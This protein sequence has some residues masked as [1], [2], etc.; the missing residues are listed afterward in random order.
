MIHSTTTHPGRHRPTLAAALA[1][2][3]ALLLGACS[4][5][6]APSSSVPPSLSP[7]NSAG[8]SASSTPS[9]AGAP[10]ACASADIQATGG[11][12]GGAAG[13]RGSDIVVDNRGVAACLLPAGATI[14]LV[15]QRGTVLVANTPARVGTGPE[16][17]PNGT[18]GF[19]LVF[20][21]WCDQPVSLPL[22]FRLALASE[23]VDIEG[24]SVSTRDDLPP[25][26]GPGQPA[27][28]STSD[29]EL[30]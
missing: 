2:L 27:V 5:V 29:W 17:A 9:A 3:I 22:H 16:I 26:N 12:W 21:N 8:P 30:R 11:P 23:A 25:C 19:S 20:G 7:S 14:A 15:D 24:L 18:I 4:P 10:A 28:L 13:S 6:P 1:G